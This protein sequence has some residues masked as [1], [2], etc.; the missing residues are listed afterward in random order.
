[1][2]GGGGRG[3]G[4]ALEQT[5][6]SRKPKL[7]CTLLRPGVAS[8]G[9][10]GGGKLPCELTCLNSGIAKTPFSK[11]WFSENGLGPKPG[12]LKPVQWRPRRPLENRKRTIH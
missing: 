1:M 6:T 3:P 9:G 10:G 8:L 12:G 5:W 11:T 2:H 7:T 4:R